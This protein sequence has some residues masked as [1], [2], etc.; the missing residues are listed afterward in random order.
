MPSGIYPRP[1]RAATCHP[2]R[3]YVAKGLCRD[4][5][6]RPFISAW[7]KLHPKAVRQSALRHY[8]KKNYRIT[9]A[10]KER[11]LQAHTRCEICTKQRVRR[12]I[13]HWPGTTKIRGILCS[14]CNTG[15]GLLQESPKLLALALQYLTRKIK[16]DLAKGKV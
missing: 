15:I 10:E 14:N 7:V 9:L 4:C 13:D 12:V 11:L 5:Y 1:Y 6:A 8:Y 2:H 3:K 16:Y